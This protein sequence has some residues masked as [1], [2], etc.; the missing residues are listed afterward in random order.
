MYHHSLTKEK[1]TLSVFEDP[2]GLEFQT[3]NSLSSNEWYLG[4]RR[5]DIH[6]EIR[7][8]FFLFQ[9]LVDPSEPSHYRLIFSYVC[10]TIVFMIIAR[11][12]FFLIEIT[13]SHNTAM[14]FDVVVT[15]LIILFILKRLCN[16]VFTKNKHGVFI[17]FD[18]QQTNDTI[19]K[20]NI[21]KG[22]ILCH[23]LLS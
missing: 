16:N 18:L 6:I 1:Y 19:W 12:N 9:N 7:Y 21:F 13:F 8:C 2:S 3:P 4:N 15:F 11:L 23:T 22:S 5:L 17:C 10:K 14:D 20:C